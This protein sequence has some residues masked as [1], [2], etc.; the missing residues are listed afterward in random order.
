MC[1]IAYSNKLIII[2]GITKTVN[3]ISNSS[4]TPN[5]EAIIISL[6]K[7]INLLNKVAINSIPK[8]LFHDCF[9]ISQNSWYYYFN[10]LPHKSPIQLGFQLIPMSEIP[11]ELLKR[12]LYRPFSPHL[13][14][15]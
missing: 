2:F 7:P 6:K 3:R 10:L 15:M 9:I 12:Q 14:K 8:L 11:Y 1:G 5:F 13:D 4:A